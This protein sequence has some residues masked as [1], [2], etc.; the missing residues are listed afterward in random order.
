MLTSMAMGVAL[1]LAA[2]AIAFVIARF[3]P[4]GR[5]SALR[6][7]L[8]AALLAAALFGLLATSLDFGGLRELDWRAGLFALF[9]SLAILG[10]VRA[11]R[12]AQT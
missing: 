8:A 2:G 9:G 12:V 7:E 4:S 3:V 1:W 11:L 5:P 6:L 10:A